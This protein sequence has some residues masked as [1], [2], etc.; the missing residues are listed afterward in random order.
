MAGIALSTYFVCPWSMIPDTLDYAEWKSGH[1]PEG[2]LYGFFNLGVKLGFTVSGSLAAI[3]LGLGG[4]LPNVEQTARSL[5][6]IRSLASWIPAGFVVLSAGLILCYPLS[7]AF[8]E[9]VRAELKA[10]RVG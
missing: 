8:Q 9:R 6:A 3:V 7:G 10:R 5:F 1:R 2:L 4:Y